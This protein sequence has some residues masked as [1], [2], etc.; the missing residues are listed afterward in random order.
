MKAKGIHGER[1]Y[2]GVR[3]R[4]GKVYVRLYKGSGDVLR[5]LRNEDDVESVVGPVYSTNR[6]EAEAMVN[7]RFEKS[8]PKSK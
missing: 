6:K 4:G 2:L 1:P 5:I 8:F 3:K 7:K